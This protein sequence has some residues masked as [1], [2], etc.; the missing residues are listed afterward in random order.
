MTDTKLKFHDH[1]HSVVSRAG[2]VASNV[3]KSTLCCSH[4]FMMVMY[5]THVHPLLE[6]SSVVWNTGYIGNS[7]LLV[8]A[9]KVDQ[10]QR[11]SRELVLCKQAF[12]S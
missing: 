12:C 7:K 5:T 9:V 2:G 1:I 8:S 11:W 4:D 3:L 6:F 10:K